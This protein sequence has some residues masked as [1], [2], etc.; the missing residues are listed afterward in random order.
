MP[1]AAC[2]DITEGEGCSTIVAP[3]LGLTARLCCR[4]TKDAKA[5]GTAAAQLERAVLQNTGFMD[6]PELRAMFDAPTAGSPA[7]R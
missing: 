5:G 2:N 4:C 6:D 3:S 1:C 7:C